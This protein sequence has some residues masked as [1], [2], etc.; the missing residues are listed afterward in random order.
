MINFSIIVPFF[1]RKN[2]LR[3]CIQSVLEQ[4]NNNWELIMVDDGSSDGAYELATEM[5][6]RHENV[7]VLKREG[8][9]KGGSVCR[10]LGWIAAKYEYIL[11]LDS[12]DLLATY[13]IQQRT[14]EIQK[15][16]DLNYYIFPML[17]FKEQIDDLNLL[18]N[19]PTAENPLDRFLKR[20]NVWLMSSLVWRKSFLQKLNGFDENC[21]SFQD[22]EI[23]VRALLLSDQYLFFDKCVPDNFYRQQS[24]STVSESR[25]TAEHFLSQLQL[26]R[27]LYILLAAS[28]NYSEFRKNYIGAFYLEVLDRYR[29][30]PMKNTVRNQILVRELDL[31]LEIKLFSTAEKN[32]ILRYLKL[33]ASVLAARFKW[34]RALNQFV[35]KNSSLKKYLV[36]HAKEQSK[37]KFLGRLEY[38]NHVI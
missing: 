11:F 28:S 20:E 29:I 9:N 26:L 8:T 7:K 25:Y 13:C 38:P 32:K 36:H 35:I 12:D 23:N 18:Q 22:W 34:I 6:A 19:I 21:L 17:L 31:A 2:L 10:N 33:N 1:N 14:N 24:S 4:K 5:A 30:I 37:N 3:E 16:P 15:I 27:N